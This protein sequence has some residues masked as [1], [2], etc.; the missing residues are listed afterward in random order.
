[1][2][3]ETSTTTTVTALEDMML[4]II[5]ENHVS[6]YEQE[7][8]VAYIA[9]V[10]GQSLV[11]GVTRDLANASVYVW[12]GCYLYDAG[13]MRLAFD[14]MSG[15]LEAVASDIYANIEK[16]HDDYTGSVVIIDNV[17][18][19]A[20]YASEKSLAARTVAAA[21]VAAGVVRNEAL[22]A[23]I[24]W[25]QSYADIYT[26]LGM[27]NIENTTLYVGYSNLQDFDDAVRKALSI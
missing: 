26:T 1:M 25:D 19:N 14:S 5:V 20:D 9:K 21:L 2:T 4:H 12:D 24:A 18:I 15:S 10:E 22:V 7:P 17:D 3:A 8:A 16:L 13:D 11:D 23:G 6:V 27:T